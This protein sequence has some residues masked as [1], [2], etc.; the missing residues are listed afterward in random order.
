MSSYRVR[1]ETIEFGD[2]DLHVRALRDKQE[3][4][5][6]EGEAKRLGITSATWSIFGVLWPSSRVL[7]QLMHTYD[8]GGRRVLEVG[9][10][11]ALASL[12]LASRGV[13][14]TATDYHPEAQ[15][16]LD[17]NRAL[18]QSG[19]IDF[20]R[21]SWEDDGQDEPLG[22]FDLIIGSDVLYER[23]MVPQLC[24]F[25]GRHAHPTCEL[26]LVDPRRENRGRFSRLMEED[27]WTGSRTDVV[28]DPSHDEP[29]TGQVLRFRRG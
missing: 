18:N 4:S 24:S 13:D 10:G 9:C 26:M 6:D 17:A 21:T 19:P 27:G 5:D 7:A 11:L 15:S 2:L 16:F 28:P 25:I 1:Y 23:D 20:F 29:Y 12:V 3:F 22:R 8:V 14:V